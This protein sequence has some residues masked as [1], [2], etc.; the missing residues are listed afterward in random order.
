MFRVSNILWLEKIVFIWFDDVLNILKKL[1]KSIFITCSFDNFYRK[2]LFSH[3]T[4]EIVNLSVRRFPYLWRIEWKERL[5]FHQWIFDGCFRRNSFLSIFQKKKKKN[6]GSGSRWKINSSI[7]LFLS[8]SLLFEKKTNLFYHPTV[9]DSSKKINNENS[10]FP[11]FSLKR[12]LRGNLYNNVIYPSTTNIEVKK[13][14][15]DSSRYIPLFL[16]ILVSF[17]L[18]FFPLLFL[19]LILFYIVTFSVGKSSFQRRKRS[20]EIFSPG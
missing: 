2:S 20:R 16:C 9:I 5:N 6:I 7:S 14:E 1:I 12:I 17:F 15:Q 10:I 13:N 8:F 19:S 4:I 11:S 18:L 3:E